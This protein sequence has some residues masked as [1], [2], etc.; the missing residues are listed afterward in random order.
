MRTTRQSFVSNML[1]RFFER[2]G[3][4]SVKLLV[5]ILLARLL[6]P[7]DYGIIAMVTVFISI[8]NVFVDSGLGSSLI[9]KKNADQLDFST[10]FWFNLVWCTALYAL[11]YV[12]APVIGD[13]YKQQELVPVIRVLGL[14]IIISGVK[15]VQQS[16]VS[17]TMQFKRFFF[18]TLGGTLGAAV[19]GIWMAY[20]GYGVWA[21]VVQQLFNVTVG[22]IIL[23]FTVRWRPKLQFSFSRLG[24]LFSFGWKLLLSRLIDKVYGDLRQLIIGRLYTA[25]DLAQYNRGKQIPYLFISNVNKSIDSVLFPTMSKEQDATEKVKYLTRRAITMSTY[26][27]APIMII[28]ISTC[29]P[30]INF[31]LTP[32][33]LPC[34]PFMRIFCITYIFYPI[35]TANL[36][37]IKALGRSDIFLKLEIIKK[38]VGI[39]FIFLTMNISVMAM[40]YSFLITSVISQVINSWPNRKILNYSY[41]EQLKDILPSILLA[42]FMGIC[43]YFI[44]FLKMS[45][46]F[47]VILQTLCGLVIYILGSSLLQIES[48]AYIKKVVCQFR[49]SK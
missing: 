25:A 46:I 13:F 15:N 10:V 48:Y 18:A 16:Y 32:K 37:A 12:F 20:S 19:I 22:T 35:H 8:L 47:T 24:E 31:L 41:E 11:L 21:L 28:L 6:V 39:L 30:L 45:D 36:N 44:T 23:W 7:E 27:L 38:V 14:Q 1:W 43:I 34:V 5:E 29:E 49:N 26:I 40:A 42:V 3:A 9:Q 33:W 2:I 17:R 4:Q